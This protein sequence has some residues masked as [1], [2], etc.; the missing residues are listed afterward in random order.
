MT[1]TQ[2]Y[3]RLLKHFGK[4]HWW[5]AETPFEVVVGAILTQNTSWSNV[6][7]A[8]RNLK[9]QNLLGPSRLA[10]AG[11]AKIE[12]CVYPAG[13]YRQKAE[14]LSRFARYLKKDYNGKLQA[15]LKQPVEKLRPELLDFNGIGP[16]TCDSI[17]LYAGEK[18]VFPIDAYT[19]RM[20]KRLELT[21]LNSYEELRNFFEERIPPELKVY[22]EFHALIVR[23]AKTYCRAKKPLC[24]G[25]PLEAIKKAQ[26]HRG[27]E[28][29]RNKCAGGASSKG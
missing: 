29:Q 9:A 28:F 15:L 19:M 6:E 26:R 10:A 24:D 2:I 17:L 4:Q 5:P 25:C 7:M 12:K 1:L 14:R 20:C 8:I 27:T 23:W 22:R 21:A 16:E 3:N 11:K 13:F 18:L